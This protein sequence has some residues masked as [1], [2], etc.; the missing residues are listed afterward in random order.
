MKAL[1]LTQPWA[2]LIA[3]GAKRIETRSWSTSYRGPIAIHAAKG[4]PRDCREFAYAD[5]AGQVLND[6]GIL[7]GGDCRDLPRGALVALATLTGIARTED[8]I[9]WSQGLLRHEIDFGDY[10]PGR[11]GWVLAD[12]VALQ[13]PIPCKGALGLWDV[14]PQILEHIESTVQR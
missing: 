7:L 14:P 8:I 5:P 10:S 9:A 12:V 6:A 4:M 3:I 1:S 11:F 2:T 13:A